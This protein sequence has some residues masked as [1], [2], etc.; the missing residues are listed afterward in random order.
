MNH[1][2]YLDSGDKI[3]HLTGTHPSELTIKVVSFRLP[4]SFW[5][6][7]QNST[8]PQRGGE[9][10]VFQRIHELRTKYIQMGP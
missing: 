6:S 4:Q 7:G 1:Y 10:V 9:S 8:S 3:F 2:F 5:Q